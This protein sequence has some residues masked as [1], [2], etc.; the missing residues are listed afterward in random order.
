MPSLK[1]IVASRPYPISGTKEALEVYAVDRHGKELRNVI[2]K[3]SGLIY[4]DPVPFENTEAFYKTEYRKSYKGIHT[5]K[6]KHIYRAGKNALKRLKAIES[7]LE[8]NSKIL[9][10][11]CSSG[12]FVY[13]AKARGFDPK[14]L[15][16]NI[17]YS[18]F[19]KQALGI[20][21]TNAAFS[22]F[23]SETTFDCITLFH[24]LE[25]LEH[26]KRDLLHLASHL[27][28]GGHI[29]IEVPNIVYKDMALKHKW[30]PGHL[31]S[32]TTQSLAALFELMGFEVVECKR[33]DKNAN[34]FGIFK[35]TSSTPAPVTQSRET[36][37][38]EQLTVQLRSDN[39]AYYLNIFN[40]LKPFPK[41]YKNLLEKRA[42]ANK[43][44]KEIL[45]SLIVQ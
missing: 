5:P 3:A 22:E 38:A 30:H 32:Y 17:S 6:P 8:P 4:V 41:L 12:E 19:A 9:D 16:A 37:I 29:V 1:N 45:D 33:V 18:D 28:E 23:S 39:T 42:A 35:K 13:L 14:G 7:I 24:V 27:R 36:V 25:H 21:V 34:V 15:E 40:Y 43:S 10:A 44:P 26:P 2:N 11:G 31:Y 20:D